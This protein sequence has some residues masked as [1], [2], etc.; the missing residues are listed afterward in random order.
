MKS[1]EGVLPSQDIEQ[2]V[3]NKRIKA[4]SPIRHRQI[5]PAS[6]D[7]RL[8]PVAH[9]IQAS[10]LPGTGSTVT[11]KLDGLSMTTVNLR[12]PTV[13]ETG[14]VYLAELAEHVNLPMDVRARANPKSTT[15]RLDIFTRIITDHGAAFE[16]IRAGYHGPLYAEIMPRTFPVIVQ[17]GLCLSQI[18]F[19]RGDGS[20]SDTE[21]TRLDE[22]EVLVFNE[23]GPEAA[24]VDGGIRLSANLRPH[25]TDA[26]IGYRGRDNAPIVDMQGHHDRKPYWERID[27]CPSQR[28]ILNPGDFYILTSRERVRVPPDYAA[29]MVP[30]DPRWARSAS[31]MRGS[32]TPASATGTAASRAPARCSRSGPTRRRS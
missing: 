29:E 21:L 2:L 23:D 32:S 19:I 13:L 12:S 26:A 27:E 3:S 15:G 9:R 16:N 4:T 30:Y 28:L 10:F 5:Q 24:T 25:T 31:T 14:C 20:L 17:E 11:D 1:T 6:I 8:G 22:S 7:L 18:R